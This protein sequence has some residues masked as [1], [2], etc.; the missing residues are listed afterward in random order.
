MTRKLLLTIAIS[1]MA[2]VNLFAYDWDNVAVPAN[3]G[4]GKMWQLQENVS[5]DFNYTFNAANSKTNFGSNKWYNFY[6]NS[7]DGPG[8]TYW[9]YNNVAVNSGNLVI[10]VAKSANT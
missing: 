3:A 8:T 10:S 6:H 1:V 4:S 7:W 9:Q 5:D 2:L